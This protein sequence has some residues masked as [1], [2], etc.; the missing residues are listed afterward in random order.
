MSKHHYIVVQ[1]QIA[2]RFGT[3]LEASVQRIEATTVLNFDIFLSLGYVGAR[4][5]DTKEEA[6]NIATS[7]NKKFQPNR[8]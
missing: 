3:G 1:R 6:E 4:I 2:N 8:S 5:C 7:W